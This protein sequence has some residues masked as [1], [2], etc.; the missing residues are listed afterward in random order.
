M[1]VVMEGAILQLSL[2]ITNEGRKRAS[3]LYQVGDDD[4]NVF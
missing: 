4:E 1:I 2:N 3:L